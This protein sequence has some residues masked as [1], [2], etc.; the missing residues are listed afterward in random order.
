MAAILGAALATATSLVP[1][2]SLGIDLWSKNQQ[3]A[4]L[5]ILIKEVR[6][7]VNDWRAFR[8][9][10]RAL[11]VEAALDDILTKRRLSLCATSS[12][13]GGLT[14]V[15]AP[16]DIRD[17]EGLLRGSLSAVTEFPEMLS[18]SIAVGLSALSTMGERAPLISDKNSVRYLSAK[19]KINRVVETILVTP[20]LECI[21]EAVK[22]YDPGI[23]TE[24]SKSD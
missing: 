17:V 3:Q 13:L 19:Q 12:I 21:E 11:R 22:K 20:G 14:I 7:K 1:L 5:D 8:D 4:H 15:G 9:L 23:Q 2:I 10:K 16:A 18:G 24:E 6:P